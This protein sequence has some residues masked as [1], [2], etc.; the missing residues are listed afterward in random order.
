MRTVEG[1]VIRRGPLNGFSGAPLT[2]AESVYVGTKMTAT[3]AAIRSAFNVAQARASNAA[4]IT[5]GLVALLIPGAAFAMTPPETRTAVRNA[6]I[7]MRNNF[8][9]QVPAAYQ[10][11]LAGDMEPDRFFNITQTYVDGL[12]S[13]LA[14]LDET[15][16]ASLL[17]QSTKDTAQDVAA[18]L[19][20]A[21]AG[22]EAT[23]SNLPLIVTLLGVIAVTMLIRKI[24]G[25][26]GYSKPR[27]RV[28]RSESLN[29]F[30]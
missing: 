4:T 18:F 23:F 5:S 3:I 9:T 24:P 14:E 15:T 17:F 16:N 8:E 26:D 29:F 10:K 12:R 27:K 2:P 1:Q 7:T 25:F 11:V 19:S 20:K 22:V 6:L 21:K 30:P 28:R 13:V